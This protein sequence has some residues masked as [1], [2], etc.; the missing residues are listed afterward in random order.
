MDGK[1]IQK[2]RQSN[3]E[4][5]R[6][7]AIVMI[8]GHHFALHG[9]LGYYNA[10]TVNTVWLQFLQMGGKIGV[11]LFVL[12]SGYFMVHTYSTKISKVLK[13]WLQIFTYS[14]L[15][16]GAI[17]MTNADFEFSATELISKLFPVSFNQWWFASAYFA[18]LL[19]APF[20]NIVLRKLDKGDYIKLLIILLVLFCLI[21]TVFLTNY[22]KSNLSWFVFLYCLSGYFRLHCANRTGNPKKLFW[23]AAGSYAALFGLNILLVILKTDIPILKKYLGRLFGMN[24][25]FVLI[26]SL[27]IFILFK[28][29][30]LGCNRWINVLAS[31]AFGIYLIHDAKEVRA[32]LARYVYAKLSVDSRLLLPYSVT[33]IIGIFVICAAIELLRKNTLERWYS[34]GIDQAG[35]KLEAWISRKI[36]RIRDRSNARE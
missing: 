12:I 26:V 28:N 27:A 8:I 13:L 19:L 9:K 22:Q 15:V 31:T 1:A 20:I 35:V 16:Y 36:Q 5:L 34:K 23:V 24:Q 30:N 10:L 4:L 7:V 11:N 32:L 2:G 29:I 33:V 17:V 3:F 18:L 21:P 14:V 6:I 25:M